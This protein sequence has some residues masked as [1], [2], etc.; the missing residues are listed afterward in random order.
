MEA[1]GDLPLRVPRKRAMVMLRTWTT[2]LLWLVVS[3]DARRT[4]SRKSV[5][6]PVSTYVRTSFP[7]F[8]AC[9]L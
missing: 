3:T 6:S 2:S 5:H 8:A 7:F 4:L 1:G 9:S